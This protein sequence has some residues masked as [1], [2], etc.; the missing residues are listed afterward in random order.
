MFQPESHIAGPVI[1][2]CGKCI[3]KT[4]FSLLLDLKAIDVWDAAN[5]QIVIMEGSFPMTLPSA[6]STSHMS[7]V[8]MIE[9]RTPQ[10][11]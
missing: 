11:L 8:R 9:L 1:E 5:L 3:M 6:V 7:L 4:E 2:V 10:T